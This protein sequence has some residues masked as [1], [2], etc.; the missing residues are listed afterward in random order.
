MSGFAQCSH[1][2]ESAEY[3]LDPFPF[4]LTDFVSGVSRR[5]AVNRASAPALIILRYVRSHLHVPHFFHEIFGV[6]PFV[7]RH[8]HAIYSVNTL[9]HTHRRVPLGR[10]VGLIGWHSHQSR[11][12]TFPGK[13]SFLPSSRISA[14]IPN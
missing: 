9:R 5:A 8:S 6:V 10:S 7:G 3:F 1:R 14:A 2:L 12:R 4:L 11:V 13:L